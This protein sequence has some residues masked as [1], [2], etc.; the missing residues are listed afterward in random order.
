MQRAPPGTGLVA[1][2]TEAPQ[3]IY[4]RPR[5]PRFGG[6]FFLPCLAIDI[7]ASPTNMTA[8]G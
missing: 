3:M 2:A 5:K 1:I 6:V 8:N 7:R 4:L